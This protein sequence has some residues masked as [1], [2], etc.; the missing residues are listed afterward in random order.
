MSDSQ[1]LKE[2]TV[3]VNPSTYHA[4]FHHLD[5]IA[6]FDLHA[7]VSLE[8]AI[9]AG[10]E[11]LS[12]LPERGGYYD[13]RFLPSGKY[14]SILIGKYHRVLFEIVKDYVFVDD[15]IDVREDLH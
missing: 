8:K 6:E 11:S 10:I 9:T 13:N 1:S 7:A 4:M 5:F 2:Y 15:I 3:I 12:L 14:R